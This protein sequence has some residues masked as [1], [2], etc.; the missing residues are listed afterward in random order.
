MGGG[1]CGT[2]CGRWQLVALGGGNSRG[3]VLQ[4]VL[5]G[6]GSGLG[7]GGF[8]NGFQWWLWQWG[9]AVLVGGGGLGWV[10]QW[11]LVCFTLDFNGF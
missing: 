4:W 2:R 3:W 1:G 9:W 7:I 10:L 8:G 11:I 6:S 5:V